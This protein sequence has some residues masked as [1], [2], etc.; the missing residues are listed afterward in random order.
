MKVTTFFI[1]IKV[2]V[3]ISEFHCYLFKSCSSFALDVWR[4]HFIV[5]ELA[6]H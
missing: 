5:V 4:Q 6:T 1:L 3:V 2:R